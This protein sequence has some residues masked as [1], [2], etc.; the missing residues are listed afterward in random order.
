MKIDEKMSY[1]GKQRTGVRKVDFHKTKILKIESV[2][3]N[4]FYAK[5]NEVSEPGQVLYFSY[6]Q[7]KESERI[8]SLS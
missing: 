4:S 8:R 7:H 2:H 6:S 5:Q 3:L 1:S